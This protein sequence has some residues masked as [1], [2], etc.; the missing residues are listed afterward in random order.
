MAAFDGGVLAPAHKSVIMSKIRIRIKI[1]MSTVRQLESKSQYSTIR[2][3]ES[4]SQ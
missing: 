3:L 2:Q 1:T 4:K